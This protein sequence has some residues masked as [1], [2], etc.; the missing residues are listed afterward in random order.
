[1]PRACLRVTTAP[2][3]AATIRAMDET[4]V[5]KVAAVMAVVALSLA[6]ASA[7]HLAGLV[8]GRGEPYDVD[9]AGIAEAVIGIVLA[10]SAAAMVRAPARART[11]GLAATGFAIVGF[12]VGLTITAEGGHAP[13]IAYHLAVLP[14]LLGT[15]V[16]LLRGRRV[17]QP[18]IRR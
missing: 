18:S 5:R 12:G 15:F 14:V 2:Q 4:L 3:P 11:V 9:D 13:D 16:V 6:V 1:M 17:P 8:H 10:A 7:L